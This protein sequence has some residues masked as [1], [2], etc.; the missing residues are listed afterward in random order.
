MRSSDLYDEGAYSK[1]W[2]DVQDSYTVDQTA[3]V[4]QR[5]EIYVDPVMSKSVKYVGG[6]YMGTKY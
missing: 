3:V 6:H 1:L 4:R 5:L 2:I